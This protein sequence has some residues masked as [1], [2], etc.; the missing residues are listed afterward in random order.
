MFSK[1]FSSAYSH[2]VF[3]DSVWVCVF[4]KFGKYYKLCYLL[5]EKTIHIGRV[6]SLKILLGEKPI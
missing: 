4:G 2:E 1:E 3:L 6:N 5:V